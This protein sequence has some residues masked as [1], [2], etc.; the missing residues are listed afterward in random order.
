MGKAWKVAV[1]GAGDMG[2]THVQ[3]WQQA[4][5]EVISVTDV[6]EERVKQ[7][8]DKYGIAKTFADYK[9]AAADP[10]AEIVSICLPLA[11]HAPVTIYAAQQGKHIFCEKPLARSF[12]EVKAM[13]EAVAKAGVQFGIGFQR[14]FA[15]SLQVV[16]Q[17]AADDVFGHPLLIS[18]TGA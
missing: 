3:A 2:S 14:S 11:L 18:S 1:I 6:D 4:G 12:E 16:K 9:D 13:E 15:N 17:L 7:L 5:H 8:R 10:D